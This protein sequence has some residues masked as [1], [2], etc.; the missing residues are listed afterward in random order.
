MYAPFPHIPF[1]LLLHFTPRRSMAMSL[2]HP[3][4]IHRMTARSATH[5]PSANS[6]EYAMRSDHDQFCPTLNQLDHPRRVRSA[7]MYATLR[8]RAA[9][10]A[11][12]LI[13]PYCLYS[14]SR[15]RD[16]HVGLFLRNR[17][18]ADCISLA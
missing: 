13:H 16:W 5:M 17:R 10:G 6:A 3:H 14:A 11:S 9:R 1:L 18:A 12:Q 2:L 8:R 4:T 15:A 7:A